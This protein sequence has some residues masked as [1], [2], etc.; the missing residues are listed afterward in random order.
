MARYDLDGYLRWTYN[1]WPQDVLEHPSFRYGQGDEYIV[2]PGRRGPVSSIRWESLR[3]G[4]DDAEILRR[5][6]E[7]DPE[8]TRDVFASLA[9]DD[10]DT[11][12]A[13]FA[14]AEG[15]ERCL[16]RLGR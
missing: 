6:R 5:A 8:L 1:S 2:Y 9:A 7:A 13:W 15:R 16:R 3:D 11:R 12:S 10:A 14:M 4:L